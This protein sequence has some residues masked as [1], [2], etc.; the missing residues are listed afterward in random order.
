VPA[1]NLFERRADRLHLGDGATAYHVVPERTATL[2][3]EVFDI[4]NLRGFREDSEELVFHP[5]FAAPQ[6]EPNPDMGYYSAIR[7]PRL[8]SD[9]GK[10]EVLG[11]VTSAR[12]SSFRSSIRASS[13]IAP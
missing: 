11:R 7:E 1:I 4:L 5:L 8:P 3:Y 6:P 13:R 10:R 9:R 12:R 2:D